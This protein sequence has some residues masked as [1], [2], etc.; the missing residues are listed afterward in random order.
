MMASPVRLNETALFI[1]SPFQYTDTTGWFIA[2]M[3]HLN[4]LQASWSCSAIRLNIRQ[5]PH[6][7]ICTTIHSS[8]KKHVWVIDRPLFH[9]GRQTRGEIYKR[10][11][12]MKMVDVYLSC[13]KYI[14]VRYKWLN[15]DC[16]ANKL[17]IIKSHFL[18]EFC[19]ANTLYFSLASSF[20]FVLQ[21]CRISWK[22]KYLW[23]DAHTLSLSLFFF[24][25]NL[26]LRRKGVEN[27]AEE[28]EKS[29]CAIFTTNLRLWTHILFLLGNFRLYLMEGKNN[30]NTITQGE[31]KHFI[32]AILLWFLWNR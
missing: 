2:P 19:Y 6:K 22:N 14:L 3:I 26:Y 10:N 32:Q 8:K 18:I 9:K 17:E 27:K 24:M 12:L 15:Q 16:D 23:A 29:P 13:S 25:S 11:F 31:K 1:K 28:L 21:C 4:I 30:N 7:D 20:H 5:I